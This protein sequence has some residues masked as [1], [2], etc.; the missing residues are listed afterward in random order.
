LPRLEYCGRERK[1]FSTEFATKLDD[2]EAEY[3]FERLKGHYHFSQWLEIGGRDGSG[4][5]N[6]WLVRVCHEPSVGLLAHEVAHAMH[7]RKPGEKFHTKRHT[8][9]MRRVCEYI[10]RH[11]TGWREFLQRKEAECE[12]RKQARLLS[13]Q[14]TVRYKN[15]IPGRLE[16]LSEQEK[17][18]IRRRKLAETKLRKIRRKIKCLQRREETASISAQ[19]L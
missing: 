9:I 17:K 1:L 18:W 2:E 7:N 19:S 4:H 5:C 15:S 13:V 14:E 16:R 11:L 10:T 6:A 3:V 8:G 12:A